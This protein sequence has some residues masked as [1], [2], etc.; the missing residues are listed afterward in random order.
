[1]SLDAFNIVRPNMRNQNSGTGTTDDLELVIEEFSGM[2]EGSIARRSVLEGWIPRRQVKGT[3]TVSNYAV[4]EVELGVVVPGT[5]PNG[6]RADFN[7][8]SLTIDTLVYARHTLPLLDVFQTVFD[9]RRE[10]ATEQGKTIAKFYDKAF[11][12]QAIKASLLTTSPYAGT[13]GF[14]GGT[15]QGI[16]S[17][18]QLDPAALYSAIADMFAKME[19]KD[20][21][22]SVDDVMLAM[23]PEQFYALLQAEQIVNGEYITADGTKVQGDQGFIFKAFGCPVV[24]SNNY[25][26]GEVVT[27]SLL[28]NARN[29]NAYDGDFS[30]VLITAFSPRALLAGETIP[31]TKDVY[32]DKLSKSWYVDSHM[33]FGVTPSRP[34]FSGSVVIQP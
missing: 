3:S 31:L 24:R 2:V 4:G 12:T 27:G 29:S 1:M 33:S 22:P 10:L 14:S 23:K 17:G 15:Q 30:D 16:A 13:A 18:S 8:T 5:T 34:E 28:S 11:F 6:T 20:V 25:P 9:A 26:G 32:Y 19:R 21:I 7:R